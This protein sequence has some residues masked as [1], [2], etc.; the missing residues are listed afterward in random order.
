L[1]PLRRKVGYAMGDVGLSLSY[2]TVSFFFLYYLSDILKLPPYLAGLAYFIGQL[3]N[4]V[5][6]PL[7]GVINDRT[8]SRFGRKRVYL[9][10]GAAPFAMTFAL[11]W[12]APLDTSQ[13]VKFTY[14]TLSML[15]YATAYSAV[16]VPFMALVP[17][18]TRDYDERTQISGIRSILSTLGTILGGGAA[19]LV[20]GIGS[21]LTGLRILA[22][23]FGI[24]AMLTIFISAQNVRGLDTPEAAGQSAPRF[25]LAQYLALFKDRNIDILLAFKFLGAIATGTLMASLPYFARSILGR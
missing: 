10:F 11:L 12:L 9:L 13:A 6:G 4:G 24:L 19:L 7:I 8:V 21:E 17:V 16:N 1:L 14:A 5:N 18:M 22:F 3:W 25:T 20:S 2:Y 15:L 23:T